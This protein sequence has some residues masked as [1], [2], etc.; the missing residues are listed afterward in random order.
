MKKETDN[1]M[2]LKR[3]EGT[4]LCFRKLTMCR[5][6]LLFGLRRHHKTLAGW[7]IPCC[8]EGCVASGVWEYTTNERP[9][10]Q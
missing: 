4:H 5:I 6:D 2:T 10:V 1:N 8:L 3:I 9:R 7:P